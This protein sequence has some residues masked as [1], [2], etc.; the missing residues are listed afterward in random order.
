VEASLQL[1]LIYIELGRLD[2]GR[3]IAR[4]ARQHSGDGPAVA[5]S[6]AEVLARCGET[7][8]ANELSTDLALLSR[9]PGISNYRQ[10]LLSMALGDETAALSFLSAAYDGHDPE[11]I[12]LHID[13]RLDRLRG[14]SQFPAI[15]RA[16]PSE[17]GR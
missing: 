17:T 7:S 8:I 4:Q 15:A 6:V 10:S 2:E 13:P 3:N 12:W 1:A 11:S 14:H 9:V 16:V 5:A